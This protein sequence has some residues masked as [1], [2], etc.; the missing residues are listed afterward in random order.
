VSAALSP[1]ITPQPTST[2]PFEAACLPTGLFHG[3]SSRWRWEGGHAKRQKGLTLRGAGKGK[4]H[5][6]TGGRLVSP[7]SGP[8][9]LSF[10]NCTASPAVTALVSFALNCTLLCVNALARGAHLLI[11]LPPEA[12]KMN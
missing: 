9:Q 7:E 1:A 8:L 6:G 2:S 12:L 10:G 4:D 11:I 5:P 3:R